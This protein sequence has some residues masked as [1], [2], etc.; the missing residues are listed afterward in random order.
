M[1]EKWGSKTTHL[2]Q[3]LNSVLESGDNRVIIASCYQRMLEIIGDVL[4]E[5]NIGYTYLTKGST[6]SIAKNIERFRK[7]KSIRVVLLSAETASS[8]LNLTE[9]NHIVLLDTINSK[10]SS[11]IE[12]QMIAR[13]ARMGQKRDVNVKRFVVRN[14]IEHNNY[15]E[16]ATVS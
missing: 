8:G 10:N 6:F 5:M 14:T 7:E 3:Y 13:T 2:I 12:E 1:I 9:A 15:I 11:T 4:E 16:K